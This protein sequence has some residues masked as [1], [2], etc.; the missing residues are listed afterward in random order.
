MMLSIF[1]VHYKLGRQNTNSDSLYWLSLMEDPE[2]SED[3]EKDFLVIPEDVVQV[4]LWL[5]EPEPE[6]Y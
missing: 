6:G 5:E 1:E 4:C 3:L 2:V